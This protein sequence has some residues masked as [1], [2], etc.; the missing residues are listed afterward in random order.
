MMTS[1]SVL[2]SVL[3]TKLSYNLEHDFAPVSLVVISPYLLVVHPSVPARSIG[4]LIALA[5]SNPGKLNYASAGVG[6]SSHFMGE[7]FNSMAR[8]KI[9][10]L[11]YKG[12]AGIGSAT[13][14]GH[15]D[16]SFPT[17]AAAQPFVQSNKVRALAITSAHRMSLMSAIPTLN[18][19]ALPG[20]AVTGWVGILAPAG[21]PQGIIARLNAAVAKVMSLP[22]SNKHSISRV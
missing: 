5:R 11:P 19:S 7:L 6:T 2:Q 17:V 9:V 15:I 10:H 3:G 4:E 14:A 12:G 18:E 22:R 13:A 20:Y 1:S 8:V 16:I 21:V